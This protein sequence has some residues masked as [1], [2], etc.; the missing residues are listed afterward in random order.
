MGQSNRQRSLKFMKE[1]YY[2]GNIVC[3]MIE[4]CV[5]F[6]TNVFSIGTNYKGRKISI[7]QI[8]HDFSRLLSFEDRLRRTKTR[9]FARSEESAGNGYLQH[10]CYRF[11]GLGGGGKDS[12]TR[13]FVTK[14]IIVSLHR[15]ASL[16]QIKTAFIR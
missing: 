6:K 4:Q 8:L 11:I 13:R 15:D 7:V 1:E 9:L 10:N 5:A 14:G 12:V 16:A 2:N 3:N